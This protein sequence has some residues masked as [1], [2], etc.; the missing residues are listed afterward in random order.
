M[1]DPLIKIVE[2]TKTM[3]IQSKNQ[4]LFDYQLNGL[5][6]NIKIETMFINGD[7]YLSGVSFVDNT[8]PRDKYLT[9][10]IQEVDQ[11][12]QEYFNHKRQLFELPL[13][14]NGTE[15]QNKVWK[16]LLTIPYGKVCSYQDI[17]RKVQNERA[18]RAVGGANNGN[19]IGIIIPCHRVIGKNNCLIGYA[20]GI[21][22]KSELLKF[23]GIKIIKEKVI[24]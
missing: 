18:V 10:L 8:S 21:D 15:F 6:I 17:A 7:E 5:I 23:E 3:K 11:Q 1:I 20:A 16:A 24:K 14:I 22:L 12:L 2:L 4:Q 13:L 19:K 9:P